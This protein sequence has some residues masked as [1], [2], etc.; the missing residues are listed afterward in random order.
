[1]KTNKLLVL[2]LLAFMPMMAFSN[3]PR[4]V[5]LSYDKESGNLNVSAVHP[6]KDVNDHFIIT[7]ATKVNSEDAITLNYTSQSSTES[8]DVKIEMPDLKSGDIVE[9]KAT[10]NKWGSKSESITIE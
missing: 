2:L 6:V 4:K 10:C 1:M 7:V 5:I 3:P 8:Q 9:V